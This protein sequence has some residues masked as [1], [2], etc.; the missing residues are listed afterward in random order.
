MAPFLN[1]WHTVKIS[2]PA[3]SASEEQ[4]SKIKRTINLCGVIGD[5]DMMRKW[6]D[7]FIDGINPKNISNIQKYDLCWLLTAVGER[8]GFD[9]NSTNC[10]HHHKADKEE[11]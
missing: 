10:E 9:H 8:F 1:V 7:G 6:I 4:V 2:D 11:L 3:Q 5:G